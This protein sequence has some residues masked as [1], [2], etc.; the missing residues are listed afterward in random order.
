M[1]VHVVNKKQKMSTEV[2]V[3]HLLKWEYVPKRSSKQLTDP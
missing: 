2:W 1:L 3:A